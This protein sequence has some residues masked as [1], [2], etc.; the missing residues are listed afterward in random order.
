[1]SLL[2]LC[3]YPWRFKGNS[4]APTYCFQ[5]LLLFGFPSAEC[6]FVPAQN[7]GEHA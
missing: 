4:L 2:M 1:V 3:G 5:H 6:R 7:A